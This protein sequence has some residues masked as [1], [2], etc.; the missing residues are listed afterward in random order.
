MSLQITF[1]FPDKRPDAVVSMQYENFNRFE[2][3]KG[4]EKSHEENI[5][6]YGCS[7]NSKVRYYG[8]IVE[9]MYT[10]C[11]LYKYLY[12]EVDES[13]PFQALLY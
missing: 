11:I 9:I 2:I 3:C 7:H 4:N 8:E 13:I 5:K 6:I 10:N 1:I 12:P